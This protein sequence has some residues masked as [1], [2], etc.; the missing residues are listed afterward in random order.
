MSRKDFKKFE[1]LICYDL[2]YIINVIIIDFKAAK[3]TEKYEKDIYIKNM[4]ELY[5]SLDRSSIAMLIFYKGNPRI[6]YVTP[7]SCK[8]CL[9]AR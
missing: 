1:R 5:D 9:F 6:F 4:E 2:I 3:T 7:T 8:H